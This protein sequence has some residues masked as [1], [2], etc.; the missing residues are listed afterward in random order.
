MTPTRPSAPPRSQPGPVVSRALGPRA[1]F[2]GGNAAGMWAVLGLLL[3]RWP[4]WP[5][6][7]GWR[8]GSPAGAGG[9]TAGA[10]R[11]Q[12]GRR[13]GC[14]ARTGRPGPRTPTAAVAAVRRR[15]RR[16]RWLG[17][18]AWPGGC[19]PVRGPAARR[20]GRRAGP[21]PRHPAADRLAR[22]PGPRPG[23]GPSLAG[24]RPRAIS[25][26]DTGLVL[27]DLSSPAGAGTAAVRVVGGHA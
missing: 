6:W 27:G 3:G 8:R 26:A 9:G 10:V 23:C 24:T 20:P 14:A 12:V 5:G 4:R 15:A 21:Q 16:C 22:P 11:H 19:G 25:P 13:T 2:G 1:P 18:R 7:S 17:R